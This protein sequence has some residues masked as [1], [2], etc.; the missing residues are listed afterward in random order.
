MHPDLQQEAPT[1]VVVPEESAVRVW[2][3]HP[4]SHAGWLRILEALNDTVAFT[5]VVVFDGPGWS[6]PVAWKM[7]RAIQASLLDRGVVVEIQNRQ[8]RRLISV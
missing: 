7:A 4:P 3:E 5:D 8:L 2:L 6:T 1:W